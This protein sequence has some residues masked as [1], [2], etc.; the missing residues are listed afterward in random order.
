MATSTGYAGRGRLPELAVECWK[1]ILHRLFG[2]K[3]NSIEMIFFLT[4]IKRSPIVP[5][6]LEY[7]VLCHSASMLLSFIA[8]QLHSLSALQ[9]LSLS[10]LL[11]TSGP[12]VNNAFER[13]FMRFYTPSYA[14]LWLHLLA[15]HYDVVLVRFVRFWYAFGTLCALFVCLWMPQ[16][17]FYL[18]LYALICLY[19]LLRK[20]KSYKK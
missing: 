15:L 8:S 3:W 1:I 16:N 11:S 6:S 10:L 5:A 7:F 14:C 13:S 20:P 4:R 2:L 17:A 12:I 19:M 18:L 9:I